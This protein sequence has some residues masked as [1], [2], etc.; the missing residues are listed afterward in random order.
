MAIPKYDEMYR[1]FLE[2][3]SDGG[4]HKISEIRDTLAIVFNVSDDERKELLPSGK[5]PLFNNRVNWTSSYLKQAG[6][7]KN[8]SRGVYLITESGKKVLDSNIPNIDNS[9]LL[10]FDSFKEFLSR[11]ISTDPTSDPNTPI[12]ETNDSSNQHMTVS[13]ESPQDILDD[14]YNKIK[15]SLIDD[16]LS[17]IMKQSPTFFEHLVVKLLTQMGYG[18]SL[19]GAATV[20][21]STGDEGIDGIIREDKLGFNLIY[22]QAKRWD[23]KSTVGRPELQKFVGAL[24]GQGA[25]KG[26][27]ITTA[28]FTKEAIEYANKQHTTKII[29]IDGIALAELM[30]EYNVGVSVEATYSIKRIDSD[31]FDDNLN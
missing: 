25:A 18:G 8:S 17:E 22:I 10:K 13:S 6:L 30:I 16:V 28:Q 27:F 11:S 15:A 26:L 12:P 24:A 2:A 1:E 31:F 14:A 29:L 21:R 5:Q 9:F 23:R 7:I 20:T 3:L 4:S 19:K